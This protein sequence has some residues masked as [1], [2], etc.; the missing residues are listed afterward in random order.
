MRIGKKGHPQYRIVVTDKR[1]KRNT[2]YI[3]QLGTY[4]PMTSPATLKL[5]ADKF[6]DWLKKGATITDGIRKLHLQR[7]SS[8]KGV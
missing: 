2:R 7:K 4:D 5:N 1:K 8:S 3:D 6:N